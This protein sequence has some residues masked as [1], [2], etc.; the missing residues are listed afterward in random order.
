MSENKVAQEGEVLLIDKDL[1]WTSFDVVKKVRNIVR[2]KKV[3]HAGTLDPLA[4]GLLIVCTGKM[5][6]SIAKLQEF[7]KEYEGTILL[8]KTTPSFDLET[9]FDSDVDV[10]HLKEE[11]I[12]EATKQFLGLIKQRP[13]VYSA[14]KVGG[15]RLYEAA[16]AG[17]TIEVKTR[18]VEVSTFEITD[19]DLPEISFK[20]KC[21]KGTYI[22]SL[23]HDLG[24]VLGVGGVL[25]ALRRTKIGDYNVDNAQTIKEFQEERR[26]IS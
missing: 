20:V 23:A 25:V 5:T 3:G 1:D 17:E 2:M 21:S 10:S 4:T 15:R 18:N 19:V 22:R 14:I 8:G 16:R 13:P 24:S 6:K 9:D 26:S 12:K 11:Q 7:S